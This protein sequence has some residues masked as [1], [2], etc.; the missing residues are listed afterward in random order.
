MQKLIVGTCFLVFV[1][2]ISAQRAP[3]TPPID[4][5][6]F[7]EKPIEWAAFLKLRKTYQDRAVTAYDAGNTKASAQIQKEWDALMAGKCYTNKSYRMTGVV[8]I[9]EPNLEMY[10]IKADGVA[11]HFLTG[12]NPRLDPE[13]ATFAGKKQRIIV[14]IPKF[15]ADPLINADASGKAAPR[16]ISI[17]AL[18]VGKELE[19]V[20][21]R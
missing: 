5:R 6:K 3:I 13:F 12:T 9:Q 8:T 10:S 14:A 4:L 19:E 15:E 2:S 11:I 21:Y 18:V 17:P 1:Q 20:I 16:H 7:D